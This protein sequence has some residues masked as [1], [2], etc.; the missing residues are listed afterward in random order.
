VVPCSRG[1]RRAVLPGAAFQ[2]SA[3]EPSFSDDHWVVCPSFF[4][5]MGGVP[6]SPDDHWVVCPASP[7][8]DWVVCPSF[9]DDHWVVCPASPTTSCPNGLHLP[10]GH[11]H[12]PPRSS[13]L[14]LESGGLKM[15]GTL[16]GPNRPRGGALAQVLPTPATPP[17]L[18][19]PHRWR[20]HC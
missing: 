4:D 14:P 7:T 17:G 11:P 10:R 12:A 5:D 6:A 19:D 20:P 18:C 15:P 8:T 1:M 9:S 2:Q 13:S 16:G 3:A